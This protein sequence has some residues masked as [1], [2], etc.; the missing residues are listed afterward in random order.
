MS[1]HL[2]WASIECPQP[3]PICFI[4]NSPYFLLFFLSLLFPLHYPSKSSYLKIIL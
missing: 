1:F 3:S 4:L 2:L